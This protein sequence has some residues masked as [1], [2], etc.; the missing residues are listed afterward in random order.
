[1]N[2]DNKNFLSFFKKVFILILLGLVN[3]AFATHKDNHSV[4]QLTSVYLSPVHS[5]LDLK[6]ESL[7]VQKESFEFN[8]F[9]IEL[10]QEL[11]DDSNLYGKVETIGFELSL[12][13]SPKIINC[14]FANSLQTVPLYDLF[15]SWKLH[16][17]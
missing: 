13:N 9:E 5:Q 2:I 10:E 4:D 16:F 17:I 7:L 1:M 6:K 3:S 14:F 11:E 8:E 15:C 12:S